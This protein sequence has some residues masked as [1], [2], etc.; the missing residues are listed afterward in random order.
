MELRYL[1]SEIAPLLVGLDRLSASAYV[2]ILGLSTS[3][4][5]LSMPRCCVGLFMY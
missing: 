4:V 5:L 3:K 2:P 1:R